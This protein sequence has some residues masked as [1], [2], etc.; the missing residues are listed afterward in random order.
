MGKKITLNE[1][2]FVAGANGMAGKA[3][4]RALV[5]K[6]YGK[7]NGGKIMKPTRKELDFLDPKAVKK[8]FE[9]NKQEMLEVQKEWNDT[10]K[11]LFFDE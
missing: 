4:C 5:N 6:G 2:I 7:A 11:G 3:I 8:W 1:R 9:L 10:M